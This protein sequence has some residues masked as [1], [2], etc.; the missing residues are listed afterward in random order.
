MQTQEKIH[1]GK[2]MTAWIEASDVKSSGI[3]E[4]FE[5]SGKLI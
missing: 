1:I 2:N 4:I 5:A 3:I